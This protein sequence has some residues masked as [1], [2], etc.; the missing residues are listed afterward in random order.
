M[1]KKAVISCDDKDITRGSSCRSS[2]QKALKLLD[3]LQE[4]KTQNP[5]IL[6]LR[7]ISYFC[8]YFV[9]CSGTTP[10]HTHAIYEE[11]LKLS[12][13]NKIDIYHF[14]SDSSGRWFLIDY[15]DVLLHIFSEE[16]RAFYN[17]EHLWQEAKQIKSPGQNRLLQDSNIT[18]S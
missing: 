1:S 18:V 17:I 2:R 12:R 7:Q 16:A 9:V 8:D 13:Q 6:D 3:F 10:R 11:V 5:L 4:K 15:F 14:E